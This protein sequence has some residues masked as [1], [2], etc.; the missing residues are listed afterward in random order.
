TLLLLAAIAIGDRGPFAFLYRSLAAQ[1]YYLPIYAALAGGCWAVA[2]YTRGNRPRA[3]AII[4]LVLMP[5]AAF[6]GV[7]RRSA[8]HQLVRVLPP[9]VLLV[10][11]L[12]YK[13]GRRLMGGESTLDHQSLKSAAAS[14]V[15]GS[16]AGGSQPAVAG[17]RPQSP[18][19]PQRS[20]QQWFPSLLVV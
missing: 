17:G 8:P 9:A 11:M 4:P 6:M 5:A 13:L 14:P 3:A 2:E 16:F 10:C 1:I 15:E 7:F 20:F 18:S 12:L 19:L